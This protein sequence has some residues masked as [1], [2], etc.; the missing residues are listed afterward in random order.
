MATAVKKIPKSLIYEMVDGQALYYD[1][2]LSVLEA[3]RN[4]IDIVGS[5]YIQSLVLSNL[6]ILLAQKLPSFYQVLTNEVGIQFAKNSWRAADIAIFEKSVLAEI[7]QENKYI[8]RPPKLVIE[9]DTK[10]QLGAGEGSLDYVHH[11]TDQLLKFGVEK[12]IWIFTDSRKI[13]IATATAPWLTQDWSTNVDVME[14][15]T[16]N[17]E[18]LIA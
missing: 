10:V 4:I 14:G 17:I 6:I 15:I 7:K 1:G 9:V 3:E 12:V 8:N 11:K 18:S 2:Y 13:M 5:S 16:L